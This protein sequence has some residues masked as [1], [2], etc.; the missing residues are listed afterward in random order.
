MKLPKQS[1]PVL[2]I[3]VPVKRAAGLG[4][5]IRTM[6]TAVGVQACRGCQQRAAVLNRWVVFTPIGRP[7]SSG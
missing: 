6:T 1:A 2:R 4:D 5:V 3:P 7:G